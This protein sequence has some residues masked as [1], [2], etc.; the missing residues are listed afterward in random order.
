M[1]EHIRKPLGQIAYE[2]Y[3]ESTGW[4]SAITGAP[5]PQWDGQNETIKKAWEAAGVASKAYIPPPPPIIP[6]DPDR[7]YK[8][9][10]LRWSATSRCVC[11][12][13]LAYHKLAHEIMEGAWRC[14]A[15][16][17]HS[18]PDPDP[19]RGKHQEF[20]FSMY[21]IRSEDQSSSENRTTRPQ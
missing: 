18:L 16:M 11:G 13:G 5:L 19:Y 2:A 17:T 12:A 3:C 20:P 15:A 9:D 8:V 21:E 14:G 4:K 7:A 6:F 1:S 10:E